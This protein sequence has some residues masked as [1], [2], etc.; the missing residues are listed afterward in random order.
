MKK[1]IGIVIIPLLLIGTYL[2]AQPIGIEVVSPAQGG[3]YNVFGIRV[4]LSQAFPGDVYVEGTI[5]ETGNPSSSAPWSITVTAGNTSV[6][7]GYF[8]SLGPAST[9]DGELTLATTISSYAGVNIHYDLMA[10]ILKFN[11]I[12]DVNTVLVQLEADYDNYNDYYDSVQDTTLTGDQQDDV[13]ALNGFN[14]FQPLLD[15]EA[16][17]PGYN[18]MRANIES[19]ENLWLSSAFTTTDPDNIDFTYDDAENTIYNYAYAFKVGNDLYEMA[20]TDM[21]IN[22]IPV[23]ISPIKKQAPE[24]ANGILYNNN[25]NTMV[26]HAS[27]IEPANSIQTMGP[28]CKTNEK[29]DVAYVVGNDKYKVKVAIHCS[30]VMTS[31]KGKVVHYKWK[32]GEW[33]RSRT[34][35]AVFVGGTVYT[36]NCSSSS[37]F[38]RRN[39]D[40][41]PWLKRRQLKTARR[42]LFPVVFKT[43]TGQLVASFDTQV[44]TSGG[45]TLVF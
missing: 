27:F 15:F 9:A 1:I 7:T 33:K 43:F 25:S 30:G 19:A 11:S 34:K 35:M 26:R 14:E 21:Y 31:A 29:D 39:P 40:T 44:G 6:E 42:D 13:D 41:K 28:V 37:L 5:R 2:G 38:S 45:V 22:G 16:L 10:N 24:F 3:Q 12:A 18:S 8:Y 32:S 20:A 4:T 36:N 17:F 23:T